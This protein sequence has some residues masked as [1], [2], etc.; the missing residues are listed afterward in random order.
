MTL[1]QWIE[2]FLP[3]LITGVPVIALILRNQANAQAILNRQY[4]KVLE[5]LADTRAQLA[6]AREQF[7]E[8]KGRLT[9]KV[10]GLER[11]LTEERRDAEERNRE[12]VQRIATLETKVQQL[13]EE[14]DELR[15]KLDSATLEWSQRE[16]AL[17]EQHTAREREL[18]E[19]IETL[20]KQIVSSQAPTFTVE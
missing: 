15:R 14:R 7:A 6:A 19:Q 13:T 18:T 4:E 9:E 8:E 10:A 5:E 11:M 16:K 12:N 2:S 20:R 1:A 17:I 3:I